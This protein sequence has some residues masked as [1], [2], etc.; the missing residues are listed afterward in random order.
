MS[1]INYN[2]NWGEYFKLDSESPNGL[3]QIKNRFNNEIKQSRIG[4]KNFR[5]NG[6]PSGWRLKFRNQQYYIH[7]IV[8]VLTY[9]SIDPE[10][11]VDHLDGNPFNNQIGNLILK[12]QTDNMRNTR[13]Q[14]NN[15]TGVTGVKLND[16]TGGDAYYTAQWYEINGIRMSKSFSITKLGE[17]KAKSLAI[18]Y[19]EEQI[20]R[21]ISEGADYTE[22]HG[23]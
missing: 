6:S 16:K 1:N 5:K 15:K 18:A 12:S 10:M 23:I 14:R 7:R 22:R 13:K 21:L 19:R 11:V 3:I 2:I 9:G 8:W 17:E 20:T 4:T